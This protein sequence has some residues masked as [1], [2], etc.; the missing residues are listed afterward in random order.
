MSTTDQFR[1]FVQQCGG[2]DQVLQMLLMQQNQLMEPST[3]LLRLPGIEAPQSNATIK[4]D[5]PT[6]PKSEP[7]PPIDVKIKKE[8]WAKVKTETNEVVVQGRWKRLVLAHDA[9]LGWHWLGLLLWLRRRPHLRGLPF[10]WPGTATHRDYLGQEDVK[11]SPGLSS[12]VITAQDVMDLVYLRNKLGFDLAFLENDLVL[13]AMQI[14]RPRHNVMTHL[15]AAVV[16]QLVSSPKIEIKEEGSSEGS[17]RQVPGFGPRGGLPKTKAALQA[18]ARSIGITEIGTVAELKKN[19]QEATEG[20]PREATGGDRRLRKSGDSV[21]SSASTRT[22]A[23]P[24]VKQQMGGTVIP[25][26][27]PSQ[28]MDLSD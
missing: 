1:A 13:R 22:K 2:P 4:Q 27:P 24:M 21:S 26:Q 16:D 11:D 3:D 18:I 20:I 17:A 9:R 14:A 25:C 12:R 5:Q 6:E 19:I 28:E 7:S 23:P 15:R 10:P 8:Q